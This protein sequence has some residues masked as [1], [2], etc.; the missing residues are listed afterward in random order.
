MSTP[1][2]RPLPGSEEPGAPKE[3]ALQATSNDLFERLYKCKQANMELG[4][5]ACKFRIA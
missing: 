5:P 2:S 4:D 1:R 3:R